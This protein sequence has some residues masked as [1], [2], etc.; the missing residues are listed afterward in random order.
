MPWMRAH[1]AHDSAP[2]DLTSHPQSIAI[3]KSTDVPYDW[4]TET[5]R[6]GVDVTFLD[7]KLCAETSDLGTGA[8]AFLTSGACL[9]ARL[10]SF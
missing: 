9:I 7:V 1:R 4:E 10:G 5:L 8:K 3:R 6:G 2:D